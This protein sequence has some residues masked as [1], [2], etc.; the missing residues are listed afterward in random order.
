MYKFLI[1]VAFLT[2]CSN[3]LL[4]GEEGLQAESR[5]RVPAPVEDKNSVNAVDAVELENEAQ[6]ISQSS[7]D[8]EIENI[9]VDKAVVADGV[10]NGNYQLSGLSATSSKEAIQAVNAIKQQDSSMKFVVYFDFD[11]SKLKEDSI[12]IIAKHQQF[13]ANNPNL[14]L[15]LVGNTDERGTREYNL[16]LGEN[17]SISVQKYL[18]EISNSHNTNII[19][20]GEERLIGED[21]ENRRVEFIY[22]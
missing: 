20:F 1:M 4:V 13:L 14:K 11:S 17:R 9:T 15:D 19:S 7:D 5:S 12:A 18:G 2:S 16:S 10:V 22:K 21:A 3:S 8:F 6:I